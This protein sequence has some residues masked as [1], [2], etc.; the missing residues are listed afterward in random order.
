MPDPL[1]RVKRHVSETARCGA[2]TSR[3]TRTRLLPLECETWKDRTSELLQGPRILG[4]ARDLVN[5][6]RG[7]TLH[8]YP[9]VFPIPLALLLERALVLQR[10]FPL[11]DH[12]QRH[13]SRSYST[14]G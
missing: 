2:N 13:G 12:A 6:V 5:R 10:A 14:A 7:R 3:L 1:V 8:N 4:P 11:R 9:T